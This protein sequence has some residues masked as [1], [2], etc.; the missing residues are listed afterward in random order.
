MC[1]GGYAIGDIVPAPESLMKTLTDRKLAEEQKITYETQ[2][3]AQETRQAL[4][5]K[6]RLLKFKRDRKS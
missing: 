5:K 1:L 6:P 4:K 3:K 2:K